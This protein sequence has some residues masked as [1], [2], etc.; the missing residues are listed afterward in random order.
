VEVSTVEERPFQLRRRLT[1]A[2]AAPK[3]HRQSYLIEKCTELGVV[4]IWPILSERSVSRPNAPVL[5]KWRRR[6]VEAAKQCEQSWVPN[7]ELV[8]TFDRAVNRCGEFDAACL[9]HP[10]VSVGSFQKFLVDQL[11]GSGVLVFI[12]PEGGWTDHELHLAR[13]AGVKPVTLGPHILRT[14]TAAV[15]ACAAVAL[16]SD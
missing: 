3:A 6:A 1:L 13:S 9:S 4:G 8:Q 2:V 11:A 16:I 15:A 5:E 14:E 12:G 10:D 7:I